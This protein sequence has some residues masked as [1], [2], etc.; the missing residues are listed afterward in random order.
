MT[1]N[2]VIM[3]SNILYTAEGQPDIVEKSLREK[4]PLLSLQSLFTGNARIVACLYF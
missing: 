4:L 2:L 1:S 3:T